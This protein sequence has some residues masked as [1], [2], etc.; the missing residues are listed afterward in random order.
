[1]AVPT[2]TLFYFD[3]SNWTQALTHNGKNA[4]IVC[5]ISKNINSP[6]SAEIILTNK[7]KNYSSTTTSK[8]AV[9]SSQGKLTGVFTEFTDCYIR[10]EETGTILFRG[11]V[12]E[13]QNQYN[14]MQGSTIRL[15]LKDMLQE[16]ADYPTRHAPQALRSINRDSSDYDTRSEVVAYVVS[17]VSNNFNMVKKL[18]S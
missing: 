11:R 16:L 2:T 17:K 8:A 1:M 6:S 4:V 14:L 13:E 9:N 3:G 15:I 7:S 5:R 18:F 12:V 10:D